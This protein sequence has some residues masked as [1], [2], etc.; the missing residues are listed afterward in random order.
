LQKT[1]GQG[2]VD[3]FKQFEKHQTDRVSLGRQRRDSAT[4]ATSPLARSLDKSWRREAKLY[5]CGV[6]SN[7]AKVW[8]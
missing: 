3:A 7:A 4:F 5:C 1:S 8:G 2:R 6:T